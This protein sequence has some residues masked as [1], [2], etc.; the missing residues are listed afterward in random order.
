MNMIIYPI[1]SVVFAI[2]SIYMAATALTLLITSLWLLLFVVNIV[3]VQHMI[4]SYLGFK[5]HMHELEELTGSS[6]TEIAESLDAL[7]GSL[8]EGAREDQREPDRVDHT[9]GYTPSKGILELERIDKELSLA[10]K[11]DMARIMDKFTRTMSDPE[12]RDKFLAFAEERRS[13]M[14]ITEEDMEEHLLRKHS[15]ELYPDLRDE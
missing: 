2:L 6:D 1:M 15:P 5:K 8:R 13:E 10:T 4:K 14:G 9:K 3:S 11:D 12:S 7:M